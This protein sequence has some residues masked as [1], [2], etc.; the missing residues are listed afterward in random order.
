MAVE[1]EGLGNDDDEE[2]EEDEEGVEE[3]GLRA[4]GR[5]TGS[6]ARFGM[7][8]RPATAMSMYIDIYMSGWDEPQEH[9][10]ER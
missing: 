3:G 2:D 4:P 9:T 5:G 10:N 6:W 7:A 8:L 1:E